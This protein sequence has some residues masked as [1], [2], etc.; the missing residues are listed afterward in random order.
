MEIGVGEYSR[1]SSTPG[2]GGKKI[3]KSGESIGDNLTAI[4]FGA[5][6]GLICGFPTN[7]SKGGKENYYHVYHVVG[8]LLLAMDDHVSPEQQLSMIHWALKWN[9]DIQ[10]VSAAEALTFHEAQDVLKRTNDNQ[11]KPAYQSFEQL[12]KDARSA[13]NNDK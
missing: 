7:F 6:D 13:I 1:K 3:S 2:L 10:N 8:L 11:I 5:E 12:L 9:D 4:S